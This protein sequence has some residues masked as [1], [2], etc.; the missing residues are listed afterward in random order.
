MKALAF[1]PNR[2]VFARAPK[3]DASSRTATACIALAVHVGS[4]P[5]PKLLVLEALVSS[6]VAVSHHATGEDPQDTLHAGY[7]KG[8]GCFLE[9]RPHPDFSDFVSV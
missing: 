2:V 8:G 7:C 3:E 1:I 9:G 4:S 6:S 5:A